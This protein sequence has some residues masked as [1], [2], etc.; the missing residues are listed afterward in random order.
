MSSQRL[1]AQR[2]Q[3][4]NT[5][6]G[7][8]GAKIDENEVARPRKYSNAS[9]NTL[10]DAQSA[11]LRDEDV[12]PL[13]VSRGTQFTNEAETVTSAPSVTSTAPLYGRSQR[14]AGAWNVDR[15]QTTASLP[16]PKDDKR[17]SN[18]SLASSLG[19]GSKASRQEPDR[20][21]S[22]TGQHEKLS[23][24]FSSGKDV[25]KSAFAQH[26]KDSGKNY[27]YFA[28]NM[29]FFLSGRCMNAKAR[30]LNVA[31]F[32]LTALP[33]C[34]F[35][36]F[37]S[38]WLWHNV[39]P[40]IPIVFAYVFYVTMSAFLHAALSDPG[41]LPR[42]IHPHPPNPAEDGDP[43]VPGPVTTE[44]IMVKT[45]SSSRQSESNN[46]EAASGPTTAM[47][48]PTKYCKSCN[49]WRPPRTHHCRICD[50]CMETQ[51]HHCVWLNNCVGR[52]NY[53]FFFTYVSFASLLALLLLAFTL[54]HVALYADHHNISFAASLT[55]R[56]PE[57]V[58]FALF[59]YA[60]LA[61]PY[62]GSLFIYH[63]FLIARG[64]TT[65]E[66]LNSHKFLKKDRHRPFTQNS[67]RRNWWSV[68]LRPRTPT[69]LDFKQRHEEG[70]VRLGYLQSKKERKR[71]LEGRFSVQGRGEVEMKQ[72]GSEPVTGRGN[73]TPRRL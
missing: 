41:I 47:E 51:D 67:W 39:S 53:R 42:N 27:E 22:S 33:A 30:P 70:D 11:R 32:I 20:R 1:Q 49:I 5:G 69:F 72:M 40:A 8:G 56:T 50:A 60:L 62:P 65:R 64:E 3:R 12:P 29:L 45:F 59:L 25:E 21:P 58:S 48:V 2:N 68:L 38:S 7:Q 23:S 15:G 61:L 57:R 6:I 17:K 9:V 46:P 13:P 54:I 28:G 16:L 44:W 55:G 34:L 73:R 4:P 43:L 19:F 37:S 71:E 36:G 35:F 66:Y 14:E 52:R 10:K 26:A 31:T 63:L 24:H 18:R